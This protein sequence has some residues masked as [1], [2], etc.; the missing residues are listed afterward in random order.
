VVPEETS[1][2]A[3]KEELLETV[4]SVGSAPRLYNEEPR[5][6]ECR[7]Q[8]SSATEAQKRWRSSSVEGI[9]GR[10]F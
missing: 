3:T 6:A 4:F 2:A 8:L 10:Q 5:P 7:V 9:A 1:T